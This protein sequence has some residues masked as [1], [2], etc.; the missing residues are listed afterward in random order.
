MKKY[1]ILKQVNEAN[2]KL[3]VKTR[4]SEDYL[5]GKVYDYETAEKFGINKDSSFLFFPN[6]LI[7]AEDLKAQ[8]WVNMG[9]KQGIIAETKDE[10]GDKPNCAFYI[11]DEDAFAESEVDAT[12]RKIDAI[13]KVRE[14]S[15]IKKAELAKLLGIDV[16]NLNLTSITSALYSI[17]ETTPSKNK[18]QNYTT[19]LNLLNHEDYKE[20]LLLADIM[21]E[22]IVKIVNGI[23]K[24]GDTVLGTNEDEAILW[25]KNGSNSEIVDNWKLQLYKI[26][27]EK[28]IVR[29]GTTKAKTIGK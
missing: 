29:S 25:L 22:Q 4:P 14:L 18:F 13:V 11:F 6:Q 24:F 21:F 26:D 10:A 12:D 1:T 17:A 19:I 20:K 28:E 7:D 16:R 5:T 23:Y 3:G 27:S 9:K 15:A 8:W 2:F